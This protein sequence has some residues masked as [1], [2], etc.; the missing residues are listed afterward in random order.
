MPLNVFNFN[1]KFNMEDLN[2][3]IWVPLRILLTK[4]VSVTS[5]ERSFS[6]L[7]KTYLRSSV[8]QEKLSS[9][10]TV[11]IENAITQ[12]WSKLLQTRKREKST[13]TETFL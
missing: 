6:K 13:L 7:I 2:P 4:P 12:N 3:D 9:L 10:A 1:K 11:S 5:G 8:S